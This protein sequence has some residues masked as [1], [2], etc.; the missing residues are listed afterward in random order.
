MAKKKIKVAPTKKGKHHQHLGDYTIMRAEFRNLDGIFKDFRKDGFKNL[1][2]MQKSERVGRVLLKLIQEASPPI[3]LLGAVNDYIE[4]VNKEKVLDAYAFSNFELWLNQFSGV[5]EEENYKI[6]ARIVGKYIPREEYQLYFPIGMGKKYNGTH[7]VTAHG[8]PDLDTTIASFWGWVDAFAARVGDG[9]HLWNV[10]GGVPPQIEIDFLF[11]K[12]FGANIFSHFAKG[13]AALALSS[14]DLLSQRGVVTKQ[15]EESS[16]QIDQDRNHAVVLV[17]EK[18]YYLGDWRSIDVEGVRQVIMLLSQVLRWFENYLHVELITLFAKENLTRKDFP[19]FFRKVFGTRLE[20]ATPTQ[21]LTEKQRANLQDYLVKVLRVKKG[22]ESTFEGF[23]HAMKELSLFA[24]NEF[25]D[26]TSSLEKSPLFD[27]AGYLLENRPRI[28]HTLEKLIRYLDNAIQS[29]GAYVE[30]LGVA[31]KIKT[32]VFG[33]SPQML[34]SRAD[35]EEIRSK[36]GSY[37]YLT[38]TIADQEGRNAPLGVVHSSDLHK[39]ILGT[40]TLRDFCNREETKI[41]S[42]LEVISVIDHHKSSMTTLSP[43]VVL[44]ADAQSS[45]ALVAS[46][47]FEINDRYSMGGMSAKEIETQMHEI[48]KDLSNPKNKRLFQR[49]LQKGLVLQRKQQFF[50][51]P[52]RETIEYLHFFYAILDDT[53]LLTKMSLRDIE[54]VA[55][56]LNRLKSLSLKKEVEII[57][58][59]DI[60]H[61]DQYISQCVRR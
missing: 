22:L 39:P 23:A 59:D 15:T 48:K 11:H 32:E 13:R 3:F 33:H 37:Q 27:K 57:S 16:L 52:D 47:A 49:L 53:D 24:F 34:S 19:N 28:F 2:E 9:L 21:Q 41:P 26:L 54:C 6:R 50:I 38:V 20:Q 18:G 5:G 44:I 30:K 45:N 4:R 46:L 56:L 12:I 58:F 51:D 7:Y 8:S 61:D 1:T 43:S 42:Y 25:V 40:V 29:I 35:L 17:D 31:F 55:S 60:P 14:L 10:P 36:M